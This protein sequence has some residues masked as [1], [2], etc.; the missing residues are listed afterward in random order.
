[1][2]ASTRPALKERGGCLTLYLVVAF[3]GSLLGILGAI[4]ANSA[5]AT[6]TA[7]GVDVSQY[8]VY[9]SWYLPASIVPV[10]ITIVG[11]FGVW[12]WKKWGVYAIIAS[13]VISTILSI[14]VGSFVMGIVGLLISAALLWYVIFRDKWPL[15]E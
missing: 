14:L 10:L 12:T 8:Q 1:M 13:F 5:I 3:V 15:F 11:V 2:T 6:L 7:Q 9:P 4:S